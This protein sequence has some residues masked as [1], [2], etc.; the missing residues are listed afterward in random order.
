VYLKRG[1]AG[2]F[3]VLIAL[4]GTLP[5][6]AQE[7]PD[8]A[9]AIA[10]AATAADTW[11]RLLD[12]GDVAS[13]WDSASSRLRGAITKAKWESAL[14]NARGPF[15]PFGDRRLLQSRYA[16][17]LPN[18]PPGHYVILQYQTVAGGNRRVV[19]T[20][21]PSVDTDGQWRVGGYFIRPQ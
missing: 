11:L 18:A 14:L 7:A 8:T 6:M 3:A 21:V 16:A 2:V 4:T 5:C 13:S 17:E 20:V 9:A 10:A 1:T 15:E 19:E 12:S